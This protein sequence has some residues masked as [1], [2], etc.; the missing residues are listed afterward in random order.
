MPYR[1]RHDGS[2]GGPRRL[3]RIA[4]ALALACGPL[5]FQTRAQAGDDR[6]V[7][8]AAD[9]PD[10]T[11]AI[12]QARDG[13]DGFLA[14]AAAPPP[15]ASGF[16]LKVKVQDGEAVEHFWVTPFRAAEDGF[17]GILANEPSSVRNVE[18]GQL[19]RFSRADISDWGYRKEGREVGSFTVC[20]MFKKMPANEADYYRKNY[21]F[22]C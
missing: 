5:A 14:T 12:R 6:V 3:A 22:D 2:R 21:G 11:A 17:E 10:M 8:V 19:I 13:L 15:G 20:V 16:K 7:G 1:G 18:Q 9:D 4:L